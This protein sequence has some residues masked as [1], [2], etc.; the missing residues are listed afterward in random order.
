MVSVFVNFWISFFAGLTAPLV[1][2][3]VVPLYPGFLAYLSSRLSGKES[4]KVIIFLGIVASLGVIISMLIIGLIFSRFLQSS[5]TNAIGIISPIAFLILGIISFFLIFN[6]DFGRI[7]P[8]FKIPTIKNPVLSIFIFGL[9]FGAIVLPCNPAPLVVLFALS[10]TS[11]SFFVNFLNFLFFGIGMSVPL[12]ALSILSG[13]YTNVILG[14][15]IRNKI[16]INRIAGLIMLGISAYY[17]FFV[18]RIL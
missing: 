16:I 11:T 4:R 7:I 14:F 1:A 6:L 13:Q 5:L 18:F 12:L 3:C 17:L 2:V 15:F 10:T 9:F 8:Q